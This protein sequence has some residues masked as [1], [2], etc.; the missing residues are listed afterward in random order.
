VSEQTSRPPSLAADHI[1][2]WRG[3][4][5]VC[6]SLSLS[7]RPGELLWLR[8]PNGA[9]KTTLLRALAGLLT[10]DEGDIRWRGQRV[11]PSHAEYHRD[12]LWYGHRPGLRPELTPLENLEAWCTGLEDPPRMTPAAALGEVGLTHRAR[13]PCEYLSAGQQRRAALAR[14]CLSPASLWLLDEPL[15]NLDTAARDL[16]A[17]QMHR[18]LEAGGSIVAASHQALPMPEGRMRELSLGGDA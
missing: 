13:L 2:I 15:T 8:G 9:G 4:T 14:L 7:V 16:L 6:T 1:E 17:G 5:C 3:E 12:L 11:T 18:H 10:V